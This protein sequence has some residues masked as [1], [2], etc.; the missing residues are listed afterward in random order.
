MRVK[1]GRTFHGVVAATSQHGF[2]VDREHKRACLGTFGVRAFNRHAWADKIGF[3][4]PH[5]Q[6]TVEAG[7][8]HAISEVV[9]AK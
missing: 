1:K 4:L 2:A 8:Y 5:M 3:R 9:R 6:R 7:Y